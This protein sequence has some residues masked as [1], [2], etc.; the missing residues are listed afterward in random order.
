M[1]AVARSVA[2]LD[3]GYDAVLVSPFTRARQTAEPVAEACG[4]NKPLVETRAL[5]PNADPVD[6]LH[7]L[8]RLKPG[9]AL[10]VG[11]QPHLGRL[12]GL[13]LSG[14]SDL[15]IP[16]KKA[17]LAAFDAGGDPSLGRAELKFFLSARVLEELS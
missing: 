7:E 9:T 6:V 13:L 12:F 14:R 11:H 10:L 3:P 5:L 4:F 8:A 2:K 17:S 16:M 15:E 1:K